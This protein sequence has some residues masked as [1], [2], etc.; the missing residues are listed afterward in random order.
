[1]YK[2]DFPNSEIEKYFSLQVSSSDLLT[3]N[4]ERISIALPTENAN[5]NEIPI[6]NDYL[7]S[8]PV[9]EESSQRE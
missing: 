7:N 8:V 9:E 2:N 5:S 3:N 4:L 1:M 6:N